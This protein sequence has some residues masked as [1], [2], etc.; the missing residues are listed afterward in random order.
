MNLRIPRNI[1]KNIK[2][3]NNS[4]LEESYRDRFFYFD[5]NPLIFSK[6]SRVLFYIYACVRDSFGPVL[7]IFGSTPIFLSY[8]YL[9]EYLLVQGNS[10]KAETLDFI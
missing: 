1:L 9:V 10:S 3:N 7:Q 8:G 5:D 4:T 6:Y 2:D